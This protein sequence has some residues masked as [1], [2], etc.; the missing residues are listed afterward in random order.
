MNANRI[1]ILGAGNIGIAIAE[2]LLAS[3]AYQPDNLIL[4]RRNTRHL[5]GLAARGLTVISDNLAAARGAHTILLTVQPGQ[6]RE[7]IREILPA[8]Q[9]GDKSL[10]SVVTGLSLK[11]MAA[12]TGPG[13]HL[14]RAMPNTAIAIRESMTCVS[15]TEESRARVQPVLDMFECVGRA[16]LIEDELM[17]SATVLAACGV[18]FALRYMRASSQGGTEIGFHAEEAQLIAAQTVKGAAALLLETGHHPE[19]EIDKVT[20]PMG[21]T[22]AGLNEMEHQGFSSSLIRGITT[23]HR[24]IYK[25]SES[26]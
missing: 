13:V 5:E 1:A 22:I 19:Y 6:A 25:I 8:L 17:A 7:V 24:K 14:F 9:A 15:A 21:C 20:T 16:L 23:S 3:G 18:A 2:G 12:L 10:V 26:Q 11:D 4:T